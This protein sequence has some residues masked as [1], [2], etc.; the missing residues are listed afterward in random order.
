M[1]T[2]LISVAEARDLIDSNIGPLASEAVA[3]TEALDRIAAED[4]AAVEPVPPFDNSAMDGYAVRSEDLAAPQPVRLRV[5]DESRAGRPA[6]HRLGPGE[7]IA[8]STGAAVPEGADAVVPIELIE[9]GEG[10]IETSTRLERGASIRLQGD[11]LEPGDPVIAAGTRLGPAELGSL[12]SIGISSLNCSRRPS[13][14]VL[15]TGD[16]LVKPGEPLGPGQIRNAS[17]LS[18]PAQ[19]TRSGGRVG[20]LKTVPDTPVATREGLVEA[21]EHD[22]VVVCGGVSV[23]PHDHVKPA[24]AELGV[25][26]VF[27]RVA[28]RPGKPT[29][30]GLHTSTD[31]NE[32]RITPVFG[33]PGNPVSA[34]VTFH[35]FVNFALNLM[36]G[37]EAGGR[38][39]AATFVDRHEK[40]LGRTD[41]VRCRLEPGPAGWLA[42]LTR[43]KQSSHVL[44]SMLSAEALAEIPADRESF[45]PNEPVEVELIDF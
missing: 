22:V 14:A 34:M 6:R 19:V 1:T 18:I 16:E 24:L 27:W 26:Q 5:V 15:T 44:T 38:R 29:W 9:S 28:V 31:G 3:L 42:R 36:L 12:A 11:D 7:A 40:P 39:I 2:K 20:L 37:A 10:W 13:V 25:K 23:G 33:L 17:A 43:A 35:L 4:V 21:L 8:I 30:F 32:T 41:Y 45:G